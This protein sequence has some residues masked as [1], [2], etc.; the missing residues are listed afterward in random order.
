MNRI[1]LAITGAFIAGLATSYWTTVSL[2]QGAPPQGPPAGMGVTI[3]NTPV[4]VTGSATVSG[5]VAATQSGPWTVQVVNP[6]N[7]P[8]STIVTN[9]A[10]NPVP[11]SDV[12]NPG[13]IPYQS[14]QRTDTTCFGTDPL[15]QVFFPPVPSNHRLVILHV[16]GLVG[17]QTK[18]TQVNIGA[19]RQRTTSDGRLRVDSITDFAPQAFTV[20]TSFDQSVL[21]YF[22]AGDIPGV[23][24]LTEEVNGASSVNITFMKI[25]L[26][27][28]LINCSVSKCAPIAQ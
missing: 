27:G 24:A 11:T 7:A 18:P 26:S 17:A 2:A 21:L 14:T 8:A 1:V 28:Y 3:L 4:P 6:P 13:R 23:D 9:Q 20:D 19:G 16:S 22:D 25:N 15:C 5:T 12:D 10:T